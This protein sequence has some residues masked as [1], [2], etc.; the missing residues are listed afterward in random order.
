VI[1]GLVTRLAAL[2]IV[3]NLLVVFIFLLHGSFTESTGEMVYLYL[4]GFIVLL[5]TG[6]GKLSIDARL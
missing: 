5:F 1:A 6:A 2:V 4:G 3:L